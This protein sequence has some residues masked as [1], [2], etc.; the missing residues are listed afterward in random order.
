[1]RFP[2]VFNNLH[3]QFPPVPWVGHPQKARALLLTLNP[4]YREDRAQDVELEGYIDEHL[5][6]LLLN[7]TSAWCLDERFRESGGYTYWKQ[8]LRRLVDEVGL[9]AVANGIAWMEFFPYCSETYQGL[10]CLLPSQ[11]F[12]FDLVR[13][14]VAIG[15]PIVV[16]RAWKQWVKAVPDLGDYPKLLR[17]RN[18]RTSTIS[19]GNLGEKPF[20]QLADSLTSE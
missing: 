1:M 13:D 11:K 5:S 10:N 2:R 3:P 15:K 16:L 6:T 14:A 9:E 8:K 20:A 7:S 19:P 12:T 18:P 17:C 4:G